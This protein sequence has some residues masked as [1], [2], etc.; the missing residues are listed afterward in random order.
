[1]NKG[2][3]QSRLEKVHASKGEFNKGMQDFLNAN[4]ALKLLRNE[5]VLNVSDIANNFFK[6]RIDEEG[7][8]TNP[9]AG[10]GETT[11]KTL[12]LDPSHG[13][14]GTV[15]KAPYRKGGYSEAEL[16]AMGNMPY[17][18]RNGYNAYEGYYRAPD[19]NW[20]PVDQ[21]KANYYNDNYHSYRGW[22]E[23]MR[24][25]YNTF[26]T[27][28]GY[29][30]TWRSTGQSGSSGGKSYSNSYSNN[31]SGGNYSGG[32][33]GN[34]SSNYSYTRSVSTPSLSANYQPYQY[35]SSS[36]TPQYATQQRSSVSP[37]TTSQRSNR[38]YNI[39]KNW[40]F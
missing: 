7:N 18:D 35:S 19:G 32:S 23:G 10:S 36:S 29:T 3:N 27:F 12:Y 11:G 30:P 28:D 37:T 39:M 17:K 34:K 15:V 16:M 25:Y 13:Q 21:V 24:D 2:K 40:S 31:Y 20:Y 33:S 26:G 1:M 8:T 4:P 38:I 14:G 6:A 22:D 5:G 9:F